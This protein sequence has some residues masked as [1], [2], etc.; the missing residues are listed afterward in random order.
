MASPEDDVATEALAVDASETAKAIAVDAGETA[1]AIAVDAGETAKAI[2]DASGGSALPETPTAAAVRV[3]GIRVSDPSVEGLDI[4]T[5]VEATGPPTVATNDV[6]LETTVDTKSNGVSLGADVGKDDGPDIDSTQPNSSGVPLGADMVIDGENDEVDG[7]DAPVVYGTSNGDGENPIVE[8]LD[9]VAD[10]EIGVN[11]DDDSVEDIV[12]GEYLAGD[13]VWSKTKDHSWW[14]GQIY[15]SSDASDVAM[16]YSKKGRFLV[17]YFGDATFAWC[18]PSQLLPFLEHFELTRECSSNNHLSAVADAADEIGRLVDWGMT[19]SCVP[20]ENRKGLARSPVVNDGIKPGVLAPMGRHTGLIFSFK[21]GSSDMFK[22]V[23]DIAKTISFSSILELSILKGFL[24]AFYRARGGYSLPVYHEPLF[25]EG[26]EDKDESDAMD[27]ANSIVAVDVPRQGPVEEE[28]DG[29]G[30]SNQEDNALGGRKQKTMTELLASN[31][32]A[33]QKNRKSSKARLEGNISDTANKKRKAKEEDGNP[34]NIIQDSS[35]TRQQIIK[36]KGMNSDYNISKPG[37]GVPGQEKSLERSLRSKLPQINIPGG[38][39]EGGDV[40]GS[41]EV[42]SPRERKK[43]KYLS[44]PYTS[45]R[46]KAGYPSYRDEEK[47]SEKITK[48]ARVGERLAKAT[49]KLLDSA[50]SPRT[51]KK[52]GKQLRPE[53]SREKGG[54]SAGLIPQSGKQGQNSII[55]TVDSNAAVDEVL[56]GLKCIAAGHLFSLNDKVFDLMTDFIYAFRSS[57]YIRGANYRIYRK[58]QPGRKR[59]SLNSEDR[60]TVKDLNHAE[61]DSSADHSRGE[62]RKKNLKGPTKN[63]ELKSDTPKPKKLARSSTKKDNLE[64]VETEAPFASSLV[65]T[66][67][68]GVPLP[69]KD[70]IVRK[71]SR[72]GNINGDETDVL[73]ESRNVKI[74]YTNGGCAEEALGASLRENPFGS[75]VADYKLCY[76]SDAKVTIE[77]S[78]KITSLLTG[79]P[80]A[81]VSAAEGVPLLGSIKEK[82]EGVTSM[83]E[84]CGDKVSTEVMSSLDGE[85]KS[86]FEK[87]RTIAEES[88]S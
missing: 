13:F 20:E 46:T 38:S 66:F 80:V 57:I 9:G 26:L 54:E 41:E 77:S 70:E 27:N 15:D 61:L 82:L 73:S 64:K 62:K 36:D 71:F 85:V 69:N 48:I 5:P 51:G 58:K 39:T 79:R 65:L 35:A 29:N 18:L 78:S 22:T 17:A 23:G 19:C 72:F 63:G 44:P 2:A 76:S 4:N 21:Y 30:P 86:I 28:M 24:S 12:E 74:V 31:I 88:S 43:S 3:N 32:D 11:E 6:Q 60:S 56:S 16:N 40:Q 67:A 25:V 83:L 37:T 50:P 59:E 42:I 52:R 55:C 8:H 10:V 75:V 14:P 47:E 1:K 68:P 34:S 53:L 87:V 49:V 84:K 81:S 7:S 33:P 45:P